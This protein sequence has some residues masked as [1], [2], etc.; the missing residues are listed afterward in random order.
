V[1]GTGGKLDGPFRIL[2]GSHGPSIPGVAQQTVYTPGGGLTVLVGTGG[3]HQ[4][5]YHHHSDYDK[6][7]IDQGRK[8]TQKVIPT[9]SSSAEIDNY[10]KPDGEQRGDIPGHLIMP[11][12]I[13]GRKD[14][15]KYYT[16]K[17]LSGVFHNIFQVTQYIKIE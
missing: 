10:T 11:G 3:P 15:G 12:Q 13:P 1:I 14:D 2:P 17:H 6:H 5:V 7:Q 9:D 4:T 8:Q 16:G